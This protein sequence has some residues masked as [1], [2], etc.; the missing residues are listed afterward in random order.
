MEAGPSFQRPL[1]TSLTDPLHVDSTTTAVVG[2]HGPATIAGL[3]AERSD[4]TIVARSP[5]RSVDSS[6]AAHLVA[7]FYFSY[8]YMLYIR[9]I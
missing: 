5:H 7:F 4:N 3:T 6:A 1:L 8:K 2:A 9:T